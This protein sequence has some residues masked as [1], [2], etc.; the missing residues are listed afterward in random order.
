MSPRLVTS[1]LLGEDRDEANAIGAPRYTGSRRYREMKPRLFEI[2]DAAVAAMEAAKFANAYD[3][4]LIGGFVTL[5]VANDVEALAL[6]RKRGVAA[7]DDAARKRRLME[8]IG[9]L[10]AEDY[11]RARKDKLPAET[12]LAP[13][14]RMRAAIGSIFSGVQDAGRQLVAEHEGDAHEAE[15]ASAS[16][17]D[18]YAEFAMSLIETRIGTYESVVPATDARDEV[19][20]E[21]LRRAMSKAAFLRLGVADLTDIAVQYNDGETDFPTKDAL[22]QALAERFQNETT[23]VARLV[24]S[25][26]KGDPEVGLITRLLPLREAPDFDATRDAFKNLRGHYIEVRT[27]VFYLF[28]D[29]AEAD[30]ILRIKGRIR[31]F[32]VNPAEAGGEV[33]LNARPHIED[34]VITTRRDEP[35]VEVNTRRTS[36]AHTV[37]AVLRRT[38]EVIPASEVAPPD[39]LQR[40][41]FSAWDPRTI[42]M[43]DFLLQDL[44]ADTLKL[45]NTLMAIFKS[46]DEIGDTAARRRQPTVD[47]VQLRGTH[48]HEHPEACRRIVDASHLRDLE[49]RVKYGRR[50][51]LSP[52]LVRFRLIWEDDHLVVMSGIATDRKEPDAEFHRRIVRLV[53]NAAD[54]PLHENALTFMLTQVQRRALETEA[55]RRLTELFAPPPA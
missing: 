51:D 27:A 42:W 16:E 38:G 4:R 44:Q 34:I 41:P 49:I 5:I 21:V 43:L 29:V 28:G 50:N 25:K 19:P 35:W 12:L 31:S 23:E 7:M 54:R 55:P 40:E 17:A 11:L 26:E 52:P 8:F 15:P 9:I 37:R 1:V 6:L 48:L 36:D 14:G 3:G 53:R 10:V 20:N 46:P 47:S 22:A 32:S 45:D 24:L 33:R 2:L 13:P 30:D 18:G 39:R